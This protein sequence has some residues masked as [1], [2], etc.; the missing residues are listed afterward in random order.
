MWLATYVFWINSYGKGVSLSILFT[1][2]P[3]SHTPSRH[4]FT[5]PLIYNCNAINGTCLTAYD[6]VSFDICVCLRNHH[7]NQVNEL[8]SWCPRETVDLLS[9]TS[10]HLTFCIMLYKWNNTICTLPWLAS[11]TQHCYFQIYPC[12]CI[13]NSFLTPPPLLLSYNYMIL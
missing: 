1:L 8:V 7:H 13:S 3:F 4:F 5:K 12:H 2:S 10:D 6:L 11:F 9:V